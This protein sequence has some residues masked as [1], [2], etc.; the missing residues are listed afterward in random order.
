MRALA[1]R[2]PYASL[3]IE[4]LKT[5]EI[6]SKT[7]TRINE[8][9]AIYASTTE[10]PKKHR[11]ELSSFYNNLYE[12]KVI[13]FKTLMLASKEIKYGA[14]GVILG[15]VEI[16]ACSKVN[17]G[18]E[19]AIYKNEHLAPD[20]YFKE[21]KTYFWHL[22]RPVKFENPVE[23]KWPSTGSWAKIELPEEYE[24]KEP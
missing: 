19:Y 12:N 21:G 8:R 22:R 11:D 17:D 1:V 15:T 7:T 20:E 10:Y 9:V 18:I 4:R 16:V 14:T 5:I 6:R 24:R 2:H 13:D 3:I 23:I